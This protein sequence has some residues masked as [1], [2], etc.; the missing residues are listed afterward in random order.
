MLPKALNITIFRKV[1]EKTDAIRNNLR[2]SRNDR[3]PRNSDYQYDCQFL[4]ST[5]FDS[6]EQS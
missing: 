5:F 4:N 6:G 3:L 1:H 2:A